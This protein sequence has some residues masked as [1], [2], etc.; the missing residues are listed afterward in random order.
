MYIKWKELPVIKGCIYLLL[1]QKTKIH[2][3]LNFFQT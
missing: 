3:G 1:K 2:Q